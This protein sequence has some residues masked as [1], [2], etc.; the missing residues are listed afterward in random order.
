MPKDINLQEE[1]VIELM[2]LGIPFQD[3]KAHD[4]EPMVRARRWAV[5]GEDCEWWSKLLAS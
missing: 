3:Q 4:F 2:V 1:N 5:D